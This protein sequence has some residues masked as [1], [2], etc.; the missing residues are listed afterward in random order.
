MISDN[1]DYDHISINNNESDNTT[2]VTIVRLIIM[3]IIM[4]IKRKW[5]LGKPNSQ[6]PKFKYKKIR[7]YHTAIKNKIR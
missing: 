2:I 6:I 7:E 3:T 4:V 5:G 1:D